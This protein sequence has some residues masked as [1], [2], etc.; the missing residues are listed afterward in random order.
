MGLHVRYVRQPLNDMQ[1]IL[2]IEQCHKQGFI[3]RDIKPDVCQTS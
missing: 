3:H 2:A 1:M